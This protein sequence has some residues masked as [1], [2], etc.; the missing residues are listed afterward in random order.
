MN[1][2][3]LPRA[4][5]LLW[6]RGNPDAVRPDQYAQI[7]STGVPG[8]MESK[9]S[10]MVTGMLWLKLSIASLR[11]SE[12]NWRSR[13]LFSDAISWT[14]CTYVLCVLR[15]FDLDVIVSNTRH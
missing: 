7:S 11:L 13:Y 8:S 6:K 15:Y 5:G 2:S 1:G 9:T 4:H 14:I 12:F 10:A 3:T